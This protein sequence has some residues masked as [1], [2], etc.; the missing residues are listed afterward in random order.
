MT[1][2]Y[3]GFRQIPELYLSR[4]LRSERLSKFHEKA[5]FGK[6][7]KLNYAHGFQTDYKGFQLLIICAH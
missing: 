4:A 6:E 7:A 5:A 3:R 1:D 2:R